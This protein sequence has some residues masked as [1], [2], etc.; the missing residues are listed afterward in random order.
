MN[1]SGVPPNLNRILLH[2]NK[3][4]RNINRIPIKI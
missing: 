3:I 2:H 4:K 1:S